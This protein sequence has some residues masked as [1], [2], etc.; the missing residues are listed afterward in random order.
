MASLSCPDCGVKVQQ[1]DLIC[2]RCGANL[3]H[4]SG[5]DEDLLTPTISQ[6]FIAAADPSATCPRCGTPVSDAADV[7]CSL[8]GNRCRPGAAAAFRPS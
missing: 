3:P 4:V 8:C 7:V 5:P 6:K 2:F 1:E